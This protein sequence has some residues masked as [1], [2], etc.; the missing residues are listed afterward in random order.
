MK[1][2]RLDLN[3]TGFKLQRALRCFKRTNDIDSFGQEE[4]V[5]AQCGVDCAIHFGELDLHL[6]L[7]IAESHKNAGCAVTDVYLTEVISDGSQVNHTKIQCTVVS[8]D[9]IVRAGIVFRGTAEVVIAISGKRG[10]TEVAC[11]VNEVL[12]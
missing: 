4:R 5:V 11:S 3:K 9:R 12:T 1:I 7:S 8:K 6:I 2:S 10:D